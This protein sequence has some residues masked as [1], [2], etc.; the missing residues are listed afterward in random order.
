MV[1]IATCVCQYQ[2]TK[3]RAMITGIN[4]ENRTLIKSLVLSSK[5]NSFK[6]FLFIFFFL[7]RV[8]L[9]HKSFYR[10]ILVG[11]VLGRRPLV[12]VH[13]INRLMGPQD[14][15]ESG[16]LAG[17]A[18]IKESNSSPPRCAERGRPGFHSL[19]SRRS[20]SSR[21]RCGDCWSL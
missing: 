11:W 1:T 18:E 2:A 3:W 15:R 5:K 17:G 10:H 16:W 20:C 14:S 7:P 6:N 13:K 12:P 19:T 4:V 9:R 21:F 8:V